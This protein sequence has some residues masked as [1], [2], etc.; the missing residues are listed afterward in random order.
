MKKILT[1]TLILCVGFSSIAQESEE[2]NV[3]K[4]N[5]ISL[6]L[7]TGSVFYERE[8]SDHTSAQLGV[9]YMNFKFGDTKFSG[10]I[11]TPEF[12]IYLRK[13]AIDG[14]YISPYF[15][16]QKYSLEN[17][18]ED[19]KGTLTSMGGGLI[20]GRQWI[21]DSGFTMDLFFGGHYGKADVTVDSGPDSFDKT[22]LFEGF[23]MR[24][25]FAIG[26]AF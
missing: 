25:G 3:L 20:F 1:L 24:M 13:N 4:V 23:R 21:T 11:L 14:V 6:L 7:G 9:G 5:T 18:K 26:F 12:K 2:K 10:L 19:A 16:Y 22:G 8:I 17:S 15:R